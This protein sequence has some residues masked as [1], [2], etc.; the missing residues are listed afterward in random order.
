MDYNNFENFTARYMGFINSYIQNVVPFVYDRSLDVYTL[1]DKMCRY[2]NELGKRN[3][4]LNNC[5]VDLVDFVN[6]KEKEQIDFIN[7]TFDLIKKDFANFKAHYDSLYDEFTKEQQRQYD[8]F[9]ALANKT[10]EDY[11]TAINTDFIQFKEDTISAQ[12]T[13]ET[14]TNE[15]IETWKTSINDIIDSINESIETIKGQYEEIFTQYETDTNTAIDNLE[16]STNTYVDEKSQQI[17]EDLTILENRINED[18][19]NPNLGNAISDKMSEFI[20]SAD[21][22]TI[23]ENVCGTVIYL[24]Y[25]DSDVH[26]S[27][28]STIPIYQ[29]QVTLKK[30][31]DLRD[32][33]QYPILYNSL[34]L[35]NGRLFIPT[36]NENNEYELQEI[37]YVQDQ[38]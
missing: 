17:S 30:I 6:I 38:N 32:N 4:D 34:Y 3:N 15:S 22:N 18:L 36:K 8:E 23:L 19:T 35:F 21:Y 5:F 29:Y 31:I 9:V 16:T 25:F 28:S 24:S 2:A 20:N 33:T 11:E 7:E 14:T 1:L 27:I 12:N 10:I 13:Y 26:E 37:R